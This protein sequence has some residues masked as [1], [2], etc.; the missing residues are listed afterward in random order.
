MA[1]YGW[2]LFLFLDAIATADILTTSKTSVMELYEQLLPIS[3]IR[4]YVGCKSCTSDQINTM[5]RMCGKVFYQKALLT[6]WWYVHRW[7]RINIWTGIMMHEKCCSLKCWGTSSRLC[8]AL[9]LMG[10]AQTVLRVRRRSSIVGCSC[11]GRIHF[12]ISWEVFFFYCTNEDLTRY[13]LF[14]VQF[15]ESS[16]VYAWRPLWLIF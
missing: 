6:S 2:S 9:V 10:G 7:R 8:L 5:C 1:S 4:V 12:S 3:Q 16:I 11:L 15:L 13:P 14:S